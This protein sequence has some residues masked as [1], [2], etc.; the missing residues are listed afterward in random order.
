MKFTKKA[1]K[2]LGFVSTEGQLRMSQ[3][4]GLSAENQNSKEKVMYVDVDLADLGGDTPN[5]I[6]KNIARALFPSLEYG[7]VIIDPRKA[8]NPN[9]SR[10]EAHPKRTEL[11]KRAVKVALGPLYSEELYRHTLKLVNQNGCDRVNPST[12]KK[13]TGLEDPET[14]P[15]LGSRES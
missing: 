1:M 3:T 9:S 5:V 15:I 12:Q 13:M 2:E 11:Y 4:T 10:Q 6:T 7:K 8:L 14:T